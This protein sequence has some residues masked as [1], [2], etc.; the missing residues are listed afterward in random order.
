MKSGVIH[1][2]GYTR[3][4]TKAIAPGVTSFTPHR[5]PTVPV[6]GALVAERDEPPNKIERSICR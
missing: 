5:W 3:T 1:C 4:D 6:D 2:G